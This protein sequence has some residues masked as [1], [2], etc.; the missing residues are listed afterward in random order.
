MWSIVIIIFNIS[1]ELNT[2]VL[3]EYKAVQLFY[4]NEK[5]KTGKQ[6]SAKQTAL[7]FCVDY[8]LSTVL[9]LSMNDKVHLLLIISDTL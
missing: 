5:Q 1:R 2:N 3:C 6:Q 4:A 8:L 7:N 9:G